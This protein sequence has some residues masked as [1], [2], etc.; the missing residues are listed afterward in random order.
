MPSLL[1]KKSGVYFSQLP[2]PRA[3]LAN[4]RPSLRRDMEGDANS[5]ICSWPVFNINRGF[6]NGAMSWMEMKW[7]YFALQ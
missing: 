4:D 6:L 1:M 7:E 3:I 2:Y 5:L